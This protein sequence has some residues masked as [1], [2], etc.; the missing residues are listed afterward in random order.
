MARRHRRSA[1]K[2]SAHGDFALDF[3]CRDYNRIEM[4]ELRRV[5]CG[6]SITD[7]DT[8]QNAPGRVK[9]GAA[10]KRL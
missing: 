9:G 2:V 7:D 4:L 1:L 3:G 5:H 10:S 8:G 6:T